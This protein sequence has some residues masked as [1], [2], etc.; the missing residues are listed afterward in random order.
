MVYTEN[1]INFVGL[2]Q[3]GM[4]DSIKDTA[5][6]KLDEYLALN[7]MRKTSERYHIL[8]AACDFKGHFTIEELQEKLETDNHFNVSR[9]TIYNTVKLFIMLRL[10]V[11]HRFQGKTKYEVCN[12]TSNHCHQMCTICGKVSEFKS[13]EITAMVDNLH[14]KRFRTDGFTLYVYG[15]CSTCQANMTRKKTSKRKQNKNTDKK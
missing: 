12:I 8:Y 10:M 6:K 15:V 2:K 1:S 11:R 4:K 14:L 7:N 13:P 5:R 9:A 3:N